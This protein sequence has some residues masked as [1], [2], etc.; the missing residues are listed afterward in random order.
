VEGFSSNRSDA[1]TV[2][3]PKDLACI[4]IRLAKLPNRMN[5]RV[6]AED[7]DPVGRV[8]ESLSLALVIAR[9]A[10]PT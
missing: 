7:K 9:P 2:T 1:H 3:E 10:H 5:R 4:G 8:E 6:T